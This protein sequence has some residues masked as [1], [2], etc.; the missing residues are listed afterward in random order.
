MAIAGGPI[1][2]A[3]HTMAFIQQREESAE[4]FTLFLTRRGTARAFL[5][6]CRQ[7]AK[8]TVQKLMGESNTNTDA[9][10]VVERAEQEQVQQEHDSSVND[11]KPSPLW[12]RRIDEAFDA[13]TPE[14]AGWARLGN[15]NTPPQLQQPQPQQQQ[16]QQQQQQPATSSAAT[17]GQPGYVLQGTQKYEP[18]TKNAPV[19]DQQPHQATLAIT[20]A[21]KGAQQ[22]A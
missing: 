15:Q 16:Q 3:A 19:D 13:A 2:G 9:D 11:T 5:P 17:M 7:V 8:L 12:P 21:G 22:L 10:A 1:P 14:E 18:N 6:L 4:N 20:Q